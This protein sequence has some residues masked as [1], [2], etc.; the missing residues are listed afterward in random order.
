MRVQSNFANI[1]RISNFKAGL[2][3]VFLNPK[4]NLGRILF[5]GLAITGLT[6]MAGYTT[7]IL[8][9]MGI[10]A[11]VEGIRALRGR[12]VNKIV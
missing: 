8:P 1:S 4:F 7:G 6:A 3:K 9:G 2:R 10:V 12:N 11:V 5:G